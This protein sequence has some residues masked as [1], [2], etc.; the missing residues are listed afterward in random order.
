M[1]SAQQRYGNGH[2]NGHGSPENGV[3]HRQLFD[4]CIALSLGIPPK[5]EFAACV[6]TATA[7]ASATQSATAD[8]SAIAKPP[9]L[10]VL[11]VPPPSPRS[12]GGNDVGAGGGGCSGT[13][14]AAEAAAGVCTEARGLGCALRHGGWGV[15]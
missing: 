7:N 13:R 8:A 3:P 12:S 10:P 5:G 6:S 9:P 15:H 2:C 11:P 1:P 4:I 14:A